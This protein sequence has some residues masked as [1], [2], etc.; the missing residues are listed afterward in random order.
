L[1]SWK[2]SSQN[3]IDFCGK[4][5]KTMSRPCRPAKR[6][7]PCPRLSSES[8]SKR[9]DENVLLVSDA[10][11]VSNS[12]DDDQ[13]TLEEKTSLDEA[14]VNSSDVKL[15]DDTTSDTIKEDSTLNINKSETLE[16][17]YVKFSI[18][19]TAA[20]EKVVTENRSSA[21]FNSFEPKLEVSNN[22]EASENNSIDGYF[23]KTRGELGSQSTLESD[24]K[25]PTW[26]NE[27]I[28]I[29]TRA[30]KLQADDLQYIKETVGPAIKK[31]LA[32]VVLHQP[33]DPI[34]YFAN[35]L[36]NYRYNQHMS[37]NR[38]KELKSFMELREKMKTENECGRD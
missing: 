2:I 33:I 26:G 23:V 13:R 4:I 35:F 9:L 15:E 24:I 22:S 28:N 20:E 36:L 3:L 21:S 10:Q 25:E 38:S 32:A 16:S 12:F 6:P 27:T 18:L 19:S 11:N 1:N 29:E 37:A 14:E 30:M 5:R 7:E 31:A 17:E 34:N 8:E